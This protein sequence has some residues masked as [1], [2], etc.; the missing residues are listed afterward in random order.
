MRWTKFKINLICPQQT[1]LRHSIATTGVIAEF[2]AGM[3]CGVPSDVEFEPAAGRSDRD[4][5]RRCG[6]R[7]A[8]C[9]E[10]SLAPLDRDEAPSDGWQAG[11]AGCEVTSCK[12]SEGRVD[13]IFRF[14]LE[15]RM[16]VKKKLSELEDHSITIIRPKC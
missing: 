5:T 4:S 10:I 15:V 3:Y 6:V 8:S 7:R 13:Q 11:H 12:L 9:F 1:Y 16:P 14:M 2:G